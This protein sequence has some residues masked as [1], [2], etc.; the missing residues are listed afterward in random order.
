MLKSLLYL[1]L[2]LWL[3]FLF[4]QSD[5]RWVMTI[6]ILKQLLISHYK[7][8]FIG[9]I[10]QVEIFVI[11]ANLFKISSYQLNSFLSRV[12]LTA[13]LLLPG[14]LISIKFFSNF[15]PDFSITR[16]EPELT[17]KALAKMRSVPNPVNPL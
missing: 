3:S 13:S 9:A 15:K 12:Y 17:A 7:K 4:S 8:N 11:I 10:P 1:E 16:I 2:K 14:N 6:L 5:K